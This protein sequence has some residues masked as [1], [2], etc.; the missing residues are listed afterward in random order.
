[1]VWG[2]LGSI[3]TIYRKQVY[4]GVGSDSREIGSPK[5]QSI[6]PDPENA[7]IES[8][9]ALT[10]IKFY[11]SLGNQEQNDFIQILLKRLSRETPY[12]PIGYFI[13]FVL[14]HLDMLSKALETA[15]NQLQSDSVYGFSDFLRLLDGLLKYEH[16]KFSARMLDEI[17]RFLKGIKEDTFRISERLS[18]IRATSLA[19]KMEKDNK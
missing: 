14:Y 2:G 12:A 11:S 1:V 5:L 6:V 13:L 8:D 3:Q 19:R 18:A 17:E 4:R 10:L 15:K 9:N 7:K 16:P